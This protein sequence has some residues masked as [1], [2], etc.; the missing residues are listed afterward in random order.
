MQEKLNLTPDEWEPPLL[1]LIGMGMNEEDLSAKALRWI[2]RAE[3]LAGGKR[4]LDCFAHH[5]GVKLP[6]QSTLDQFLP[7]LESISRERRTAV[8][9]SGDPFFFGIARR[10]VN[11]FG[12]ERLLAIPNITSVQ[13]FFSRMGESWEDVKVVS[14]HGRKDSHEQEAG[15]LRSIR[16]RLKVAFLTDP[17]RTPAWIA[18][19]LVEAGMG[20]RVL[21]IAED[22]GLPTERIRKLSPQEAAQTEFSP[23]N[24]VAVFP[25]VAR[26]EAGV[27]SGT[28]EGEGEAEGGVA[29]LESAPVMGLP[30]SAFRR[31]AGLITK[32]EIRA[33]ALAHLQLKP[34]LVMWDLGA[35]SGSVSIEASRI[36]PLKQVFA[37]EKNEQRYRDILENIRRFQCFEV[38]AVHGN[39]VEVMKDLPDPDRVFI[40]GG[41]ADLPEMLRRTAERLKPSG[42][43][44][45]TAV[46]LETLE[47]AMSFW[48]GQSFDFSVTQVQVNRSAPIGES[49]R[50]D[51]LNP[52]FIITAWPRT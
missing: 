12:K 24:L 18:S 30:E 37:V 15:W 7:E 26:A 29:R 6:L 28:G 32:M 14:L 11:R 46:A 17:R 13:A 49:L 21:L 8:L 36:A 27:G 4:H 35:G 52:V 50:L 47:C 34:D 16:N 19:R 42:R 43:V 9:A 25:P 44:V 41:G 5:P 23:L 31:Q 1:V 51:A 39:V 45:L 10:L 38:R 40:G 33:V 3:V 22:L 48:R 2:E 20:D